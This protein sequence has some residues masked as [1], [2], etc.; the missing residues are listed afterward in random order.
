MSSI[1]N[2]PDDFDLAKTPTNVIV[3]GGVAPLF[4][5]AAQTCADSAP[6]LVASI[7]KYELIA[8]TDTGV[9]TFVV[10]THNASQAVIASQPIT[11]IGQACPYW[12]EG[13]FNNAAIV[14]PADPA[15]D[16]LA[17]RKAFLNGTNIKVG[18]TI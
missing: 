15:L 10:G 5:G 18:H 8:L 1:N 7:K 12:N 3:R 17:K 2:A 13:E 16:S 4:T 9:T 11:K 14:W 6:S